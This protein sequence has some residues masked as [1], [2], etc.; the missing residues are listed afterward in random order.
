MCFIQVMLLLYKLTNDSISQT[1]FYQ[2]VSMELHMNN[3]QWATNIHGPSVIWTHNSSVKMIDESHAF[4]YTATMTS[5]T[6]IITPK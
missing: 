2:A 1:L 5:I 6:V 3:K 4:D